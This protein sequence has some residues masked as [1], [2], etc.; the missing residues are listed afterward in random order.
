MLSMHT[1]ALWALSVAGSVAVSVTACVGPLA[2]GPSSDSPQLPQHGDP[3]RLNPDDF[4]TTI[5]NAYWPMT[6][7]SRWTYR[8]TGDAGAPVTVSVTVTAQTRLIANGITA[9][10]VRDTVRSGS[11]LIEDTFDWFAQDKEGNVWYLG[12]DTAVFENGV[13]TSKAGSFEAGVDG[14]QAGIALPAHPQ[15]GMTYRQEYAKGVAED[16]GEVLRT[17]ET[18]E[19]PYGRFDDA[20]VTRDTSSIEPDAV[21]YKFYVRGTGP[22]L[23]LDVS[24]GSAREALVSVGPVPD[25]AGTGPLGRPE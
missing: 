11:S 4:S 13:A 23:T 7:G 24:G 2:V 21:E 22:V 12:E 16:N 9:R 19:V 18:V 25:G 3:V 5:D 15:A 14:A 17:T 10:V 6:P 8:D 20:L 1:R